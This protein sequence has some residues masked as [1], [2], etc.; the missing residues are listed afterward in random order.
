MK[1]YLVANFKANLTEKEVKKWI[2][3]FQD[4]NLEIMPDLELVICPAFIHLDEFKPLINTHKKLKLGVQDLSGLRKGAFTGEITAQ[5]LKNEG[6]AYAILGHS[7]RRRLF[8][9]TNQ[10]V[11]EKVKQAL[12]YKITPIVC[13]DKNNF[14]SQIKLINQLKI[15]KQQI[16]IFAYEPLSAIGT[17][18]AENPREVEKI[19]LIIKKQTNSPLLYGGSVNPKN[20][21]LFL[22]PS[23]NGLLVATASLKAKSFLEIIKNINEKIK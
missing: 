18:Q 11:L 1:T 15:A 5:S 14:S 7:E 19:T 9:E 4:S 8:K 6:V 3:G 17:G 20:A 22:K 21:V 16:I 13:V 12:K 23:I 10:R 2:G